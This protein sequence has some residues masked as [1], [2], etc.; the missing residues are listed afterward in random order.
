MWLKLVIKK[1]EVYYIYYIKQTAV[2]VSSALKLP[3]TGHQ[4]NITK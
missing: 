3:N 2:L 1:R 4:N